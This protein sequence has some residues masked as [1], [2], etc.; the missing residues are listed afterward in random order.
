VSDTTVAVVRR[1]EVLGLRRAAAL[2]CLAF[3]VTVAI[4]PHRHLNSIDDL[5][6][7]AA[8]DSGSFLQC[9]RSPDTTGPPIWSSSR[10]VDDDPCLAC[11]HHD[12][13]STTEAISVVVLAPGFTPVL[14]TSLIQG[15]AAPAAHAPSTRSRAPPALA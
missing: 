13:D 15:P 10:P 3:L 11:F 2:Y 1:M 6:S 7:D 5:F 8:S 4:A 14:V 12:S 9:N